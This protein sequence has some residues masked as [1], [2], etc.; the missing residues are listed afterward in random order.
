MVAM[1]EGSRPGGPMA[2][3]SSKTACTSSGKASFARG[4]FIPG[5]TCPNEKLPPSRVPPSAPPR[6][7]SRDLDAEV[8]GH[9]PLLSKSRNKPRTCR[10]PSRRPSPPNPAARLG[11]RA[12]AGSPSRAATKPRRLGLADARRRGR[13]QI[14]RRGR[15]T[16]KPR[17]TPSAPAAVGRHEPRSSQTPG[18][19]LRVPACARPN[20]GRRVDRC[21]WTKRRSGTLEATRDELEPTGC[22]R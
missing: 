17:T 19:D 16:T 6:I 4:P 2:R 13:G 7:I 9:R 1:P 21:A 10:L 11:S 14:R 15:S 3:S 20:F 12:P 8:P 18:A 5:F 22:S